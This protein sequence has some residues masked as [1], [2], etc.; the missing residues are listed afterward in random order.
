MRPPGGENEALSV[1][2]CVNVIIAE[3]PDNKD[4]NV[5]EEQFNAACVTENS[6]ST[7][8]EATESFIFRFDR[9]GVPEKKKGPRMFGILSKR[10]WVFIK[11]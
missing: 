5:G 11:S 8:T 3:L 7:S 4:A 2:L 1:S 10:E 6:D 9:N